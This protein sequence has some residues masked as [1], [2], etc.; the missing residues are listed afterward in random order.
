MFFSNLVTPMLIIWVAAA[1]VLVVLVKVLLGLLAVQQ[2]P[3]E[4]L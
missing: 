4:V 3:L 1:E 2:A